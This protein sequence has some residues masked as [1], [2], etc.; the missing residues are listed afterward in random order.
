MAGCL[1]IATILP[2]LAR[3]RPRHRPARGLQFVLMNPAEHA[4]PLAS[5]PNRRRASPVARDALAFVGL[6][7]AVALGAAAVLAA[8]VLLLAAP[9]G[10]NPAPAS[11]PESRR[12]TQSASPASCGP[13]VFATAALETAEHS[14]RCHDLMRI[15]NVL[16]IVPAAALLYVRSPDEAR[17]RGA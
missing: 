8:L 2:G 7:T 14:G 10:A 5:A 4:A 6:A 13:Q 9:A 16:E 11:A 17:R 15:P 12:Q 1:R 3:I